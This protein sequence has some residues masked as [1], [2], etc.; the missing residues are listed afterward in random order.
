MHTVGIMKAYGKS[1]YT[2]L[3]KL[4]ARQVKT[5]QDARRKRKRS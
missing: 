4:L 1:W 5:G 3:A 2:P